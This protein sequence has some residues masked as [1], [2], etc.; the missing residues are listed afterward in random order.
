MKIRSKREAEELARA[1]EERR[2]YEAHMASWKARGWK[3]MHH[4]PVLLPLWQCLRCSGLAF[5][6]ELHDAW[7]ASMGQEWRP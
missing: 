7:H 3:P 6:R 1:E 4:E 5:D 2:E